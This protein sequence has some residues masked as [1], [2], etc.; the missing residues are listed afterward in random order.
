MEAYKLHPLVLVNVSD[1]YTRMKAQLN[2]GQDPDRVLGCLLGF[3]TGN[4]EIEICNSFEVKYEVDEG[5][6]PVFDAEYLGQQQERYKKVF[7]QWDVVG[8]YGT[9]QEVVPEVDLQIHRS[10][11]SVN[12]SPV[13]MLF[14]PRADLGGGGGGAG[15]A[16][17]GRGAA[18]QGGAGA[19]PASRAAEGA[20]TS[21][22]GAGLSGLGG[23]G[24]GAPD[25][26]APGVAT[27]D[28]PISLYEM[29]VHA[30]AAAAME[31]GSGGGGGAVHHTFEPAAYTIETVE[32]ERISVDHVARMSREQSSQAG[33]YVAHLAGVASAVEMLHSRVD[34]LLRYLRD[35]DEGRTPPDHAVL[36]AAATLVKQLPA[37]EAE[38]FRANFQAEFNDTLLMNSLAAVT[39]GTA[40]LDAYADRF[41]AAY[42]K[43]SRR[44]GF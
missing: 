7:P 23:G 22:A 38:H 13:Y 35:V 4:R 20:S 30:S 27:K 42:D 1:H 15:G 8:W 33:Q 6:V 18:T 2:A 32:A 41:N 21:G 28:L 40:E 36:R 39:K 37:A 24:G 19:A 26:G 34:A 9:G 43:H 44:R 12:E 14:N 29:V 10:L 11:S 5:G 25:G 31:E 3:Q 16:G 17:G